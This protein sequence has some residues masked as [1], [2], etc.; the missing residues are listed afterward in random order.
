MET[1]LS[2]KLTEKQTAR[3]KTERAIEARPVELPRVYSLSNY[4]SGELVLVVQAPPVAL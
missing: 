1:S 4:Y 2:L 3:K